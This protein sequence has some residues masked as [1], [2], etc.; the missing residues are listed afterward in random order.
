[1]KFLIG[2]K[3]MKT[4]ENIEYTE[5]KNKL[6]FE[7]CM[8]FFDQPFKSGEVHIGTMNGKISKNE[9]QKVNW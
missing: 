5:H 4:D 3:Q 2:V 7:L 8:S 6:A 9:L 1:M